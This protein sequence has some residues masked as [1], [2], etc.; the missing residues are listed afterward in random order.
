MMQTMHSEDPNTILKQFFGYDTFRPLQSEIINHTMSGQDC[1]VL[2]PTGGGKSI[3]FQVPALLHEGV[4][5]VVSPL[6]SLMKDQVEALQANG[7]D[8]AFLNSS[9]E[10]HEARSILKDV[11]S[12]NLKLLY[13][14]PERLLTPHFMIMLKEIPLARFAID[15]AH[16]ISTWGH[17]FRRE[18]TNL[19]QLRAHFPTIPI[20]ALTATA[21]PI[22]RDDIIAQLNLETCKRFI[23]SFDRPNIHLQVLPGQNRSDGIIDFIQD[24]PHQAGIVYC[25]SRKETESMAK[26]LRKAGIKAAHYHANQKSER[27]SKVQEQFIRDDIQVVCAT[28]AFGMGIDKSNVRFVI[29]HN[30]P[31]TMEGYYQEIGRA[32]R[33]GL[34][35]DALL[36]YSEADVMQWRRMISFDDMDHAQK[37]VKLRKL[38]EMQDFAETLSCR[39]AQILHYFGQEAANSCTNC[40]NCLSPPEEIDGTKETQMILSAVARI[41]HA[42]TTASIVGI[43]RGSKAAYI[44]KTGYDQIP[45]YGIGKHLGAP[46]WRQYI[47]QLIEQKYLSPSTEARG[48]LLTK[49]GKQVLNGDKKVTLKKSPLI[50]KSGKIKADTRSKALKSAYLSEKDTSLFEKLRTLRKEIADKQGVPAYIVF[51]D[52]SL[53]NMATKKPTT[54]LDFLKIPGVG[55]AKLERYGQQFIKEIKSANI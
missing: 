24:R 25:L 49:T 16:C 30:L 52:A 21:D 11:Y 33:D 43:L 8:A 2:M 29:H 14:A 53:V 23:A 18:Y 4:T 44:F 47:K 26:K 9:L 32:G 37:Q 13:V 36:F 19:K 48:L 35:S 41:D 20:I 12:G 55:Q 50:D 3:C 45:T 27:R 6:I 34:A 1:L 46:V 28:V 54:N 10:D 51:S 39:R 5:I 40:D 22:T 38:Q 7:I 17:S 15:E 42:L 31:A